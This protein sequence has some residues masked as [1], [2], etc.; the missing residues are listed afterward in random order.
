MLISVKVQEDLG[1]ILNH[2]Y[3]AKEGKNTVKR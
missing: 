1:N 2:R 3:L